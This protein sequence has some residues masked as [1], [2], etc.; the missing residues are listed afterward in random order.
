[1]S[2][3]TRKCGQL[4]LAANAIHLVVTLWSWL[5]PPRPLDMPI[6]RPTHHQLAADIYPPAHMC[7]EGM[8]PQPSMG[9]ASETSPVFLLLL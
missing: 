2:I 7:F 8:Q 9:D 5:Q 3:C 1:M 4:T 6:R